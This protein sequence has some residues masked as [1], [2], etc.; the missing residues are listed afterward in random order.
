[1]RDISLAGRLAWR[2]VKAGEYR[3][4]LAALILA[5]ACATLLGVVGDRLQRALDQEA[6]RMAGGELVLRDRQ[7]LSEAWAQQ[8]QSRG[9]SLTRI[10]R[11]S[12]MA[13]RGDAMLLASVTAVDDHYPLL[14]S[15]EIQQEHQRRSVQSPPAPGEIW[16]EPGLALRLGAEPGDKVELGDKTLTFSAEL[17]MAPDQGGGLSSLSPKLMV[18]L[19]S[20]KDSVLMGPLSRIRWRAGFIGSEQALASWEQ[21]LSPQLSDN[22]RLLSLDDDRPGI[23][24]ALDYGRR[25]LGQAGLVAVLLAS[26]AVALATHRQVRR[27]TSTVALLGALGV[28]RQR[29]RRLWLWQ[30]A[31]VGVFAGLLGGLIGYTAQLGLVALL[32]PLLPITLPPPAVWPLGAAV[33]LAIW[34]LLGF[35]LVPLL[36]LVSVSPLSVLQ[37]RPLPRGIKSGWRYLLMGI[38]VVGLGYWLSGDARLT[39]WTLLGLGIAGI[40]VALFGWAILWSLYRVQ[41]RF[42]WHWRQALRRLYHQRQETLLQ[43]A[44]FTLTFTALLL[45]ARSGQQLLDT[46]QMRFPEDRPD[47]FAIDIQPQEQ[48]S[49]L[50]ALNE[51]GIEHSDLYPIVRGRLS[52][53]NGEAASSAVPSAQRESN[54]LRRE[55]NLTWSTGLP[56]HNQLSAG[57]WWHGDGLNSE[58]IPEASVEQGLA[59]R[60]GL[61]LGDTLTFSI[62]G[63]SLQAQITSLRDLEWS[64]LN[65]NFYVILPPSVMQAYPHTFLGSF[66]LPEQSEG[67]L[68]HLAQRFPGVAF[69]DIRALLL[70]AENL[71]G[72]L[73]LGI[74]Y[75]LGFVVLAALLVTWAL[76]MASLDARLKEQALLRVLGA[77]WPRLRGR[78]NAEFCILGLLSGGLASVISE[79]LYS[80]LAEQM[81]GLTWSPAPMIWII[82]PLAGAG[83]LMLLAYWALAPGRQQAPHQLLKRLK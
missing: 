74:E 39:L 26:M 25:Y 2:S 65:P 31:W 76:M 34:I 59:D 52:E 30:F 66:A 69:L 75:V 17:L 29:I 24:R 22:Q 7:P 55:W 6:A 41:H 79:A 64:S 62:A 50:Q 46:W 51:A 10:A 8:A 20:L 27:Q 3:V 13:A 38:V 5:V 35:A 37:N 83:L 56:S 12:S 45:V 77:T 33:L 14:G 28:S 48:S 49:F 32:Q 63:Q 82:P 36:R 73:S 54:T 21:W 78:Q 42:S 71:I 47:H 43:L 15:I 40:V 44:T 16:L 53:I 80:V 23:G 18:N 9:L 68:R 19:E 61:T 1:M 60:L 57:Q 70:Q 58:G 67:L 4:L 81:F 11:F 72:Q